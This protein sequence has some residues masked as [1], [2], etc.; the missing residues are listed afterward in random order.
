[1][2]ASGGENSSPML[3][4]AGVLSQDGT[5]RRSSDRVYRSRAQFILTVTQAVLDSPY[6][7]WGNRHILH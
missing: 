6:L 5:T 3:V 4:I 1:M 7:P 2:L